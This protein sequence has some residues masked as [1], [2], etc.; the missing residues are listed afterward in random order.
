MENLTIE[1]K[2]ILQ[3]AKR[4]YITK[5]GEISTALIDPEYAERLLQGADTTIPDINDDGS[6]DGECNHEALTNPEIQE[7]FDND[8]E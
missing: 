8:E 3:L 6:I 7:V 2:I 4:G 1:Q 5:V